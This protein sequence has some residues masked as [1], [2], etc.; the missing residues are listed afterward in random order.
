MTTIARLF[1]ACCLFLLAVP[2]A[3]ADHYATTARY[4]AGSGLAGGTSIVCTA[5]LG[6][7]AS[8]SLVVG[9]ACQLTLPSTNV[10][11]TV[12]DDQNGAVGFVYHAEGDV[13][14]ECGDGWNDGFGAVTVSFPAGCKHVQVTPFAGS[15]SG[16]ITIAAA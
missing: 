14:V 3:H 12:E 16:L 13:G 5:E 6:A 11:I 7:A 2:A 4:V 1:A 15:L 9:G 8:T 10:S